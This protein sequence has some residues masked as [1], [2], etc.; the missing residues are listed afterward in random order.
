MS[1]KPTSGVTGPSHPIQRRKTGRRRRGTQARTGSK[2]RRRDHA[3]IAAAVEEVAEAGAGWR[4]DRLAT[5]GDFG[6]WAILESR[7]R[8]PQ[9]PVTP[10]LLGGVRIPGG[11]VVDTLTVLL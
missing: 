1:I 10:P 9:R 11:S 2:I 4:R 5:Q 3:D 7:A 8:S 6:R